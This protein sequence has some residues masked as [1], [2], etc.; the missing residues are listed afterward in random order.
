[1]LYFA[2]EQ[3]L[4]STDLINP[5]SICHLLRSSLRVGKLHKAQKSELCFPLPVGLRYDDDGPWNPL[6]PETCNIEATLRIEQFSCTLAPNHAYP[7]KV[8]AVDNGDW[9][10]DT[11]F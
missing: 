8:Y 11:L 1:V 6:M 10:A 7:R 4:E 9:C 3:L 2:Y 5:S